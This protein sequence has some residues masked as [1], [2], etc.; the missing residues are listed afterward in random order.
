MD[1]QQYITHDFALKLAGMASFKE[2]SLEAREVSAPFYLEH[3]I[4]HLTGIGLK[5]SISFFL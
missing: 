2:S 1:L 3:I 4:I 5:T